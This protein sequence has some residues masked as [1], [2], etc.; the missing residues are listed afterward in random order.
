MNVFDLYAKISLDSTDYSAAL[1]NAG[2]KF[3]SFSATVANGA[4][5]IAKMGKQVADIG[6]TAA[7]AVGGIA[8]AGTAGIAALTK[9]AVI[10]YYGDTEQLIGGVETLFGA[11]GA[12]LQEY[13]DKIGMT[14]EQARDEYDKLIAAQQ[15]VIDAAN[16]A[17]KTAGLSANEYM[18]TVT[19]FSASLLQSLGGDTA[20][21]AEIADLAITDMADNANKM[22]TSI[23]AIQVAYQGFAKQNYTMLDNL[24]LGYGGTASEMARLLNDSGVLGDQKIDLSKTNE[25]GAALQEAGF[26]KIIE[27]IHAVQSNMGITGTTA[28]EAAETIQ[29]SMSSATASVKNLMVGLADE[30]ANLDALLGKTVDGVATAAKNILPRVNQTILSIGSIAETYSREVADFAADMIVNLAAHAPQVANTVL[31][32]VTGIIATVGEHRGEMAKSA[33]TLFGVLLSSFIEVMDSVYPFIETFVPT[34]ASGFLQGTATMF[35]AGANIIIAVADGIAGNADTLSETAFSAINNIVETVEGNLDNFLG[36]GWTILEAFADGLIE[37]LSKLSASASSIVEKLLN[38]ITEN[39]PEMVGAAANIITTFVGGINDSLPTLLPAAVGMVA[40]LAI[41]LT[42]P[43]TLANI[44]DCALDLTVALAGGLIDSIPHITAAAPTIIGNLA[45]ALIE[46]APK[47]L[48]AAWELIKS[49]ADGITS[50]ESKEAMISGTVNILGLILEGITGYFKQLFDAGV[51]IVGGVKEGF[52]S[53][54]NDPLQWGKDL[55]DNFIG[56]ITSKWNALKDSVTNVAQSIKDRLG[57]SEPKEGPLSNFHTYAPDM[58][59]LF[60]QGIRDNE[61]KLTRQVEKSFDFGEKTIDFAANGR[62]TASAANIDRRAEHTAEHGAEA[63]TSDKNIVIN[64][65]V[66]GG[67]NANKT[68]LA[69]EI[70]VVLQRMFKRKEFA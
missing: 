19:S 45:G 53:F 70:A 61:K 52:M 31:G 35:S 50:T 68:E 24:K 49:L 57:F 69:E 42:S 46:S 30:N 6:T 60:C 55:V 33:E 23:E 15:A 8:A 63:T 48:T 25:I 7:K 12:S 2:E 51:S 16:G 1:K 11:G 43:D 54:I 3:S 41:D 59:D 9:S 34:I 21:A 64:I 18:E 58:I 26:A 37:N 47:L 4:K 20:K 67:E 44:I 14:A 56:G 40:Q 5:N 62:Y 10:D 38:F 13:A 28:K 65:N 27:A 36:A 17:Y 29:G 22:G 39:S 66:Q 32:V